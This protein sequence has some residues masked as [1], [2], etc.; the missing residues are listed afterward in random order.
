MIRIWV[1]PRLMPADLVPYGRGIRVAA[2]QRSARAERLPRNSSVPEVA[3]TPL[4]PAEWLLSDP[5]IQEVALWPGRAGG[6]HPAGWPLGSHLI[7]GGQGQA[8]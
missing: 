1:P 8:V 7:P 5:S 2:D 3:L 6:Y 4:M